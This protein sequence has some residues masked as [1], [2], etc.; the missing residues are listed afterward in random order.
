MKSS[1]MKLN[2]VSTF[3]EE[4]QVVIISAPFSRSTISSL[5]F[6]APRLTHFRICLCLI[7]S[8]P[9]SYIQLTQKRVLITYNF[10]LPAKFM[11]RV[12]LIFTLCL[13]HLFISQLY[14]TTNAVLT[15]G[16]SKTSTL[17]PK[18][19]GSC[20]RGFSMLLR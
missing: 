8:L 5:T 4:G 17:T 11:V 1:L 16:W 14:R 6:L 3:S 2:H 18:D 13:L 10:E 7:Y 15:P 19:W 20:Q 12:W 9:F